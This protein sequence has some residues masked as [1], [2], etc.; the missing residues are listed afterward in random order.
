MTLHLQSPEISFILSVSG[1]LTLHLHRLGLDGLLGSDDVVFPVPV[2][3]E[4]YRGYAGGSLPIQLLRS[5]LQ[6]SKF[7]VQ[8]FNLNKQEGRMEE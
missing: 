8:L 7:L 5:L 1:Q 6:L 3:D 4:R 2:V